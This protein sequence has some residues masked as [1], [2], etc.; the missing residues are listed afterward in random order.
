MEEGIS[1]TGGKAMAWLQWSLLFA[2]FAAATA[3]LAKVG[4]EGMDSNVATAI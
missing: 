1:Q 2:V 4:V 3:V